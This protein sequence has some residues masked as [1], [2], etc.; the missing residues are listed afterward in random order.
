MNL[1]ES[2]A[3]ARHRLMTQNALPRTLSLRRKPGVQ[4]DF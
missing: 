2:E 4:P 1:R 3:L